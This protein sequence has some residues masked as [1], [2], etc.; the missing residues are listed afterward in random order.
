MAHMGVRPLY[1][2]NSKTDLP[3][4][5]L[6]YFEKYFLKIA[7][8]LIFYA[9]SVLDLLTKSRKGGAHLYGP[10]PYPP[11]GSFSSKEGFFP[12]ML[13][14]NKQLFEIW[15]IVVQVTYVLFSA[16]KPHTFQEGTYIMV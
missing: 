15:K 6:L 1:S 13:M 5:K 8:F 10:H 12:L 14:I 4:F 7:H 11:N 3:K 9:E 2:Q 16:K